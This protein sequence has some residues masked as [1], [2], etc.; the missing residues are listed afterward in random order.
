MSNRTNGKPLWLVRPIVDNVI[1]NDLTEHMPGTEAEVID[2]IAALHRATGTQYA[3]KR[4]G[5]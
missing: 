3:A 4:A 2:Y 5:E 1:R